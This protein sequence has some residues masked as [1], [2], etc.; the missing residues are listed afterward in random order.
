MTVVHCKVLFIPLAILAANIAGGA[1]VF[2]AVLDLSSSDL[3]PDILM[4]SSPA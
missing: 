2:A 1:V 3:L 4:T